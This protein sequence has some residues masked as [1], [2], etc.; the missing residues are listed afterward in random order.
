MQLTL[1]PIPFFWPKQQV[2]DFYEGLLEQPID[3]IYVGEAVCSKRREMRTQDWI[4]L[5][6]MLR[7]EGKEVV[8]STLTLIEAESE[9]KQLKRLCQQDQILVEANDMSAVQL[10]SQHGVPFVTGSAINIYNGRSLRRLQQ[11]GMQRWNLP[12]ELSRD[13]LRDTMAQAQEMSE[14]PLPKVEVFTYGYLPLA[15][16][17]RCFTARHRNLAKDDCGFC[18]IEYPQGIP[19][20]SQN[21]EQLFVMNGIQT[22]SAKCYDLMDQLGSM[23]AMGVDAVRISPTQEDMSDVIERFS[24]AIKTPEKATG[25]ISLVDANDYCNGYWFGQ[26]GMDQQQANV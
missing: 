13:S 2:L 7:D 10:L 6:H 12:V 21:G 22:M 1:G 25:R 5:A 9:L 23:Q 17:A 24:E 18:C 15:Y 26:P 16:A 3:R 8:L 14:Q 11:A 20:A 19:I 4:D